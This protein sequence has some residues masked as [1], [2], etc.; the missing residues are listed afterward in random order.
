MREVSHWLCVW[1]YR[2]RRRCHSS[3]KT[4]RRVI[5]WPRGWYDTHTHRHT[6]NGTQRWMNNCP[7][8]IINELLYLPCIRTFCLS[9]T[10]QT[11]D[12][13]CAHNTWEDMKISCH[14]YPVE[15]DCSSHYYPDNHHQWVRRTYLNTFNLWPCQEANVVMASQ[16]GHTSLFNE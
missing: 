5:S 11:E 14:D 15:H 4:W 10:K 2:S 8:S 3:E 1:C 16:R 9:C 7:K 6:P 12:L 13:F